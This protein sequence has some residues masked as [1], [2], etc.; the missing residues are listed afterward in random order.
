MREERSPAWRWPVI[1][2]A[3]L[4]LIVFG[5]VVIALIWEANADAWNPVVGFLYFA[6]TEVVG[7]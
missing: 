6:L 7:G 3:L 5:G 1:V 4:L 2:L